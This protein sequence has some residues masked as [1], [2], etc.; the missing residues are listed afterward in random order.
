MRIRLLSVGN[1]PPEWVRVAV[2][3]YARRMR[4]PL[5][6]ELI[7]VPPGRG[8][9]PAREEGERLLRLIGERDYL[10][11]LDVV[12]ERLDTPAWAAM[13]ADWQTNYPRVSLVIGGADGASPALLDRADRRCSLSPLTFPHMLARVITTEQ[14]YRA[15]T[16]L[17][18]HPYHRS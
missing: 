13:L 6:F 9:K 1:R 5:G 10:V 3:D 18:G 4:A 11:L 7:E 14:L 2:D 8:S 16:I 15:W 17:Q 12:G